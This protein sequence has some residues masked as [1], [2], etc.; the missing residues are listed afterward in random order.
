MKF[1]RNISISTVFHRDLLLLPT[2]LHTQ[3][4]FYTWPGAKQAEKS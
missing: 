1:C 3:L 2:L 4:E